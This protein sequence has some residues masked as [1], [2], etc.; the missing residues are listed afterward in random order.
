[1]SHDLDRWREAVKGELAEATRKG[2]PV[3]SVLT[4]D[5]E[6]AAALAYYARDINVPILSWREGLA[7]RSYFE[8]THPF[9]ASAPSPVLL[10]SAR[11]VPSSVTRHFGAVTSA[12]PR[13]T[14]GSSVPPASS[15]GPPETRRRQVATISSSTGSA[16]FDPFRAAARAS[17]PLP[18]WLCPSG[19][20]SR[21]STVR[22]LV[23]CR[24]ATVCME[25]G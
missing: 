8:M 7:P 14:V 16:P 24:E 6:T 13:A 1:M 11:P 20:R 19:A 18:T 15:G 10:V 3:G 12:R 25:S 21:S 23:A 5:R 2:E 9:T 17:A 22:S 4:D